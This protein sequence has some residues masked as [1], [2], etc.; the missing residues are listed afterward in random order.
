MAKGESTATDIKFSQRFSANLVSNIIVLI[1]NIV[2]GLFL[3]PY[4]LDTLGEVAYGLIP[5]ATSVTS[6]VTLV[7]DSLN[8][9]VSRYLMIDLRASNFFKANQTYNTAFWGI[10]IIVGVL[11]PI[12]LCIAW[13]SPVIFNIGDQASNDVIIL[14]AL[15]LGSALVRVIAGNFM[16][17]LHAYN[18]FDLRNCIT[19]VQIIT[20]IGILITLF[21]LVTPELTYVGISYFVASILSLILASILSHNTCR[22]LKLAPK[23]FSTALV[24]DI[25]GMAMWTLIA[26]IGG[27]LRINL[28]LLIVNIYCGEIATAQYSIA[29]MGQTLCLSL[30]GVV[31]SLFIPMIYSYSA[32][33][34]TVGLLTFISFAIKGSCLFIALPISFVCL[35]APELLSLWVGQEYAVIAP[36][37][38]LLIFPSYVR[39]Q[40]SCT[41]PISS[42][43]LKVRE[44]AIMSCMFGLFN[45][46]LYLIFVINFD[47]GV[48]GIA[49]AI[50]ITSIIGEGLIIPI[51]VASVIKV[52]PL[53]FVK[54]MTNGMIMIGIL[55]LIGSIIQIFMPTTD[56]RYLIISGMI[57][58]ILYIF[59][60]RVFMLS[61]D[62]RRLLRLCIPK[63]LSNIIPKWIL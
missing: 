49:W 35:F 13:L 63:Y 27:I 9:A 18:R 34:D 55:I 41:V 15:V 20:Q 6:Y 2:I 61:K 44:V 29:Y 59:V 53:A 1:L 17:T 43:Y 56:I 8:S 54:P 30:I 5:L 40:F 19:I 38:I 36:L 48:Y 37:M 32:K 46:I 57:V 7:V 22:E 21:S 26:N 31:T 14:F 33:N 12:S 39:T 25:G 51:Y 50:L 28:G 62:E 16:L 47:F 4:F 10:L 11:I 60:I 42:A 45:V 3:T 23:Y 58:F 52:K 24:R